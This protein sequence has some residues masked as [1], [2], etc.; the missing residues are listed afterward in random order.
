MYPPD[1]PRAAVTSA[2]QLGKALVHHLYQYLFF[3]RRS[4]FCAA[5]RLTCL[6]KQH[7]SHLIDRF[8]AMILIIAHLEVYHP[9]CLAAGTGGGLRPSI[10]SPDFFF[11]GVSNDGFNN[12]PQ[13]GHRRA[14]QFP[15]PMPRVNFKDT[16]LKD[17]FASNVFNEEVQQ[18]RLPKPVFK[19]LQKTIKHGPP[20]D[21]AIADAVAIA[22][23]DWAMEKGATHYTHL[24]QPMTG[25]TAEK[26]DSFLPAHRRRQGH[27][28]IQRQGTG[29]GRA[30]RQLVPLRRPPRHLRGPRLHRLGPH[31]PRLH[32]RA[33]QRLHPG[34]PHR[35][36]S[37]DRRGPR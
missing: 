18:A 20:L 10:L 32:P 30:R 12:C 2:H 14:H 7:K 1:S 8:W 28:R 17:L 19:K 6:S 35:L 29:Q 31:Q 22:M 15:K 26:H 33:P 5:F 3:L 13:C 23:K 4:L 25:I 24:F 27:R 21:P 36:L 9:R 34:H 37:L 16:P 11:G